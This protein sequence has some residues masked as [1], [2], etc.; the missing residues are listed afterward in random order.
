[1][2]EMLQ[3]MYSGKSPQLQ[4]MALDL[5]AAADRF[6]LSGLKEM[7]DQVLRQG[8]AVDTV[9]RNLVFADMHNANEL[10]ND[11]IKYIAN[12]AS[13]I[14]QVDPREHRARS[15]GWVSDGGMEHTH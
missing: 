13:E 1:M 5:L 10:K 12:L 7:A 6:Q 3:F 11:A 2:H 15:L 4:H 14:T 9:C 8:L